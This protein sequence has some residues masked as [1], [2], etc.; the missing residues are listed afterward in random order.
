MVALALL[1]YGES[2]S[3]MIC[4]AILTY[5]SHHGWW[6]EWGYGDAVLPDFKG[7]P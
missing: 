4:I 2:S 1:I 3:I 6:K 5:A 7:A